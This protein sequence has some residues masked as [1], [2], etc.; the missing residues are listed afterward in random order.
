MYEIYN[1]KLVD[2][3]KTDEKR[4]KIWENKKLG[5]YVENLNSFRIKSESEISNIIERGN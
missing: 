5:I 2:L 1:E 3:L 4:L